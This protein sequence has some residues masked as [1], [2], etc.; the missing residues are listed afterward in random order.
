MKREQLRT[1]QTIK[2]LAIAATPEQL[3]EFSADAT[4]GSCDQLLGACMRWADCH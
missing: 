3:A 2:S 1:N 4:S